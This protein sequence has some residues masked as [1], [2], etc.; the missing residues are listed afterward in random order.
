MKRLNKGFTLIELLVVIAIIAI[1]IGLLLPAV[2]KVREAAARMKCQN[3]IKQLSLA[4]HNYHD[5]QQKFPRAAGVQ[6][7]SVQVA[8]LPFLEQGSKYN[9]FDF[10]TAI[11]NS[12]TN[13]AARQQD[14]SAYICPSDPSASR[15]DSGTYSPPEG[16]YGRS[17]YFANTGAAASSYNATVGFPAPTNKQGVF[18]R[19]LDVN[20]NAIKDGTS[21]TAFFAEVLRGN[22]I[23]VTSTAPRVDKWDALLVGAG[24]I[25]ANITNYP[26]GC[27]NNG[28]S[29]RYNG[30]Q[31]FRSIIT[32]S[33]YNHTQTPNASSGDCIDTAITYAHVA[34]RSKHVGGVSISMGDGSVRFVKDNIS[35]I[36]WSA[37]G[38][39]DGGEVVSE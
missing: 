27:N 2:Q 5:Q 31:Y 21:N 33:L 20:M 24:V 1:L 17:N 7:S 8:I 25:T 38:T 22:M 4:T 18:V 30:L 19:D 11:L 15:F 3:N 10:S 9:Q 16:P 26:A 23:G 28:N 34:S 14:V 32:T 35:L 39:R 37:M 13:R 29:L 36:T 12:A 6:G